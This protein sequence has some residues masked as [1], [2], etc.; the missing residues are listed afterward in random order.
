MRAPNR[1]AQTS[2]PTGVRSAQP[3]VSH[4]MRKYSSSADDDGGDGPASDNEW[5]TTAARLPYV[6]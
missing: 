3:T 4:L 2:A 1:C 5:M 6:V